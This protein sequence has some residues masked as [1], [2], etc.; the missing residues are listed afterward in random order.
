M[1]AGIRLR[2]GYKWAL[3]RRA[4]INIAAKNFPA[5]YADYQAV[6]ALDTGDISPRVGM[7]RVADLMGDTALA[8]KLHVDLLRSTTAADESPYLR[9]R[10]KPFLAQVQRERSD[11]ARSNRQ[12]S[13]RGQY[14]DIRSRWSKVTTCHGSVLGV[15]TQASRSLDSSNRS[16]W[17]ARIDQVSQPCYAL[18]RTLSTDANRFRQSPEFAELPAAG[19][20]FINA[21][22]PQIDT[23]L[24]DLMTARRTVGLSIR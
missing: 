1:D 9:S 24:S 16:D 19:Q 22:L 2:P 13:A 15:V 4:E 23:A 21:L 3:M 12:R 6:A 10:D 11:T 5:A 8:D 18:A 14:D 7:V 20:A 17:K